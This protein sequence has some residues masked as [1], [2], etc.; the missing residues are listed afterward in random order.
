MNIIEVSKAE[1]YLLRGNISACVDA[2]SKFDIENE[3][4]TKTIIKFVELSRII[5][6]DYI[7]LKKFE[8]VVLNACH[9]GILGTSTR[10]NF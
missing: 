8:K 2:L 6:R 3:K 7:S 4:D 10:G 9:G 1:K 5:R